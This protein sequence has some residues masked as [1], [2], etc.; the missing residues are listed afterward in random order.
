[1]SFARNFDCSSYVQS[2]P[3]WYRCWLHPSRRWAE[4]TGEGPVNLCTATLGVSRGTFQCS[5]DDRTGLR[6]V[7]TGGISATKGD[8]LLAAPCTSSAS[9]RRNHVMFVGLRVCLVAKSTAQAPR[10]LP[11]SVILESV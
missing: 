8:A 3:L 2:G 6:G 10:C 11:G 9:M 4:A 7:K 1:M 5:V